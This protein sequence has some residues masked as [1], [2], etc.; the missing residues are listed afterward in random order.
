MIHTNFDPFPIL[1]SERV[2]LRPISHADANEIFFLRS[3]ERVMRYTGQQPAASLDEI[4][5]YIQNHLH[6]QV[7]GDSIIWAITIGDEPTLVGLISYRRF[8]REHFRGEIGYGLHPDYH[9][10]GLMQEVLKLVLDYGFNHIGLHSIEANVD[11]DNIP[12]IKLLERMGFN[13][14]AHYK[15][16]YYFE[17]K[18]IDS[19]IYSLIDSTKMPE[20]YSDAP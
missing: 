4:T 7:R 20:Y 2:R 19:V 1:Q 9:G 15:E 16:N 17:G 12:S 18:F 14:E 10:K 5:L 3:D 11:K 6:V 8:Y 13:K